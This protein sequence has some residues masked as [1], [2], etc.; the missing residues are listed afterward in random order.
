MS[1]D[2]FIA[3]PKDGPEN[4]LGDGGERLFKWYSSGD[5]EF[6]W[7]SGEMVSKVSA[8]SASH[9]RESVRTIGA[10]VIGRRTFEIAN[11]WHGKHPLDV[12]VFVVTH[13]TKQKWVDEKAPFTFVTDGVES[14]IKQAKGVAG[15][16]TSRFVLPVSHSSVSRL[17]CLT[18]FI[19]TWRLCCSEMVLTCSIIWGPNPLNWNGP[20]ESLPLVSH[21]SHIRL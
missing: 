6:F 17:G 21:I 16:K 13:T 12:P 3:G 1:L 14:A 4:P 11:G 10:L 20:A 15:E 8:A 18:R 9:L 7:P 19:L 5:T 2:G